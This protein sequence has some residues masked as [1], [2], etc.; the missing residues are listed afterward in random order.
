[1]S[2]H[3]L[4]LVEIWV[5]VTV[6]SMFVRDVD[7]VGILVSIHFGIDVF[8]GKGNEADVAVGGWTQLSPVLVG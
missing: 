6:D 4:F 7:E 8:V 3:R 2:V 1:M 5:R